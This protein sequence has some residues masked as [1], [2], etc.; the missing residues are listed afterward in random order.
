[1]CCFLISA[2]DPEI[3]SKEG[4]RKIEIGSDEA[5]NTRDVL[6]KLKGE[7]CMPLLL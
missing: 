4:I 1:M 6:D 5:L 3:I 2:G 7:L